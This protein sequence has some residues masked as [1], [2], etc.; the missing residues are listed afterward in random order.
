MH[1]LAL[2][3]AALVLALSIETFFSIFRFYMTRME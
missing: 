1:P 3:L 2:A